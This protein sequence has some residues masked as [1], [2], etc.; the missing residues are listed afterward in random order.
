M[1][2]II[3]RLLSFCWDSSITCHTW[4]VSTSYKQDSYSLSLLFRDTTVYSTFYLPSWLAYHLNSWGDCSQHT[5]LQRTIC[6]CHSELHP[7]RGV[8]LKQS[9]PN[10]PLVR[11]NNPSVI[12]AS[13]LGWGLEFLNTGL[14]GMQHIQLLPQHEFYKIYLKHLFYLQAS[15][16]STTLMEQNWCCSD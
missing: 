3:P 1:P 16:C 7:V 2:A 13:L 12:C 15:K 4:V 5:T 11:V 14:S 8:S 6:C 9:V 10:M